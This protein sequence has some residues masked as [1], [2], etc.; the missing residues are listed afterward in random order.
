MARSGLEQRLGE[1][2]YHMI[3]TVHRLQLQAL[4]ALRL[5]HKILIRA[6]GVMV[7]ALAFMPTKP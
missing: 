4:A 2:I 3:S 6:S 5:M 1:E 7:N